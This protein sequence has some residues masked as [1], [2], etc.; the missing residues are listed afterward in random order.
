MIGGGHYFSRFRWARR[1]LPV[2]KESENCVKI[3]KCIDKEHTF[4]YN[5]ITVMYNSGYTSRRRGYAGKSKGHKR[6]DH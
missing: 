2:F 6:N 5:I 4:K 1:V 3:K